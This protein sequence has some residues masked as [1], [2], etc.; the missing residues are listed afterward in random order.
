MHFIWEHRLTKDDDEA[1]LKELYARFKSHLNAPP[2][3]ANPKGYPHKSKAFSW[4]KD[5]SKEHILKMHEVMQV[6]EKYDIVVERQTSKAVPGT[7]VYEDEFQISAVPW[8]GFRKKA[9]EDDLK[10]AYRLS[11][12][13]PSPNSQPIPRG[14]IGFGRLKKI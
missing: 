14:C 6:L 13:R 3:F 9:K 5:S 1:K 10:S 7:I 2:W 4:F 12:P 8:G 11:P